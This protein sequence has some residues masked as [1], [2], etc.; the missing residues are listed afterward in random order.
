LQPEFYLAKTME[1]V[2]TL[3]DIAD[4]VPYGLISFLAVDECRKLRATNK[5][6][7]LQIPRSLQDYCCRYKGHLKW[8]S[9]HEPSLLD[10]HISKAKY[11]F[12]RSMSCT[13]SGTVVVADV[14]NGVVRGLRKGKADI[15]THRDAF[16]FPVYALCCRDEEVY[17]ACPTHI[18]HF[19]LGAHRNNV[20]RHRPSKLF[21]FP[22]MKEYLLP[23][24]L[25]SIP[26]AMCISGPQGGAPSLFT[27]FGSSRLYIND[28][29]KEIRGSALHGVCAYQKGQTGGTSVWGALAC[30][31]INNQI[32][33]VDAKGDSSFFFSVP[34]PRCIERIGTTLFVSSECFLYEIRRFEITPEVVIHNLDLDL[35]CIGHSISSLAATPDGT[36]LVG[37]HSQIFA[38]L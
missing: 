14:N 12:I 37:T 21:L 24:S 9:G 8:I 11:N 23:D 28:V 27:T 6:I 3:E 2:V 18:I 26:F 29:F 20:L 1:I 16:W 4:T 22:N 15:L 32:L 17:M 33:F 38:F 25:D 30:D 5:N 7:R 10:G 13:I 34:S 19:S 36:L 35:P 31:T